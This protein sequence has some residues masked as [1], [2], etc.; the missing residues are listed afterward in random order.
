MDLEDVYYIDDDDDND[1][2]YDP[3]ESKYFSDEKQ[4]VENRDTAI[5]P[6]ST[7]LINSYKEK[8]PISAVV[9]S[10][11]FLHAYFKLSQ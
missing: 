3:N 2:K 6:I 5:E 8:L 4:L 7:D 11:M 10:K 1:V 9:V